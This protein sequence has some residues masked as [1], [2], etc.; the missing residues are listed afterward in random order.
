VSARSTHNASA[1]LCQVAPGHAY[2]LCLLRATRGAAAL[3]GTL[4]NSALVFPLTVEERDAC[5]Q[6][7][8]GCTIYLWASEIF[9]TEVRYSATGL[10]Y[11]LSIGVFGGCAPLICQVM[12][13]HVSI[14]PAYYMTCLCVV[15][16]ATSAYA[17]HLNA[18]G[19]MVVAHMRPELY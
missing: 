19:T 15:S 17:H 14:F 1:D 2:V 5:S 7:S 11:N 8:A 10:A 4:D 13:T 9:P 3:V 16:L 18:T 12:D 6:A